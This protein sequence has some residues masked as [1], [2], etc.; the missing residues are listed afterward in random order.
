MDRRRGLTTSTSGE[1]PMMRHIGAHLATID[2]AQFERVKAMC[3]SVGDVLVR[4]LADALAA[5]ERARPR[6]RL[7]QVLIGFGA[8]GRRE[9]ER[10]KS[11]PNAAV[12]RTAVY[13]L[14]EF[15]GT[16]ALPDLT[17]LLERTATSRCSARPCAPS[18]TSAPK[19]RSRCCGGARRR[20]TDVTRGDHAVAGHRARRACRAPLRVHPPTRRSPGPLGRS[21]CE[22]HRG[23]RRA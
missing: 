11:S 23:A 1:G 9:A 19:R 8:A 16:D 15:G 7:E 10:L 22:R 4:P 2:D 13:L 18:S 21:T 5:E 12:R 17:E 14:R 20:H 6:E 3:L